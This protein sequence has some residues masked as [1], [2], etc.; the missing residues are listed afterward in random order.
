MVA[1]VR[2][3]REV[4]AGHEQLRE[5]R[6][7]TRTMLEDLIHRYKTEWC[8]LME[9]TCEAAEKRKQKPAAED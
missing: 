8:P 4:T 2:V 9:A 5:V 1:H 7:E 6:H 3:R